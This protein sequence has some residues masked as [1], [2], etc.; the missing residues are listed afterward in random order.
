VRSTDD[1]AAYQSTLKYY[2]YYSS[3]NNISTLADC[4]AN[5]TLLNTTG[6]C[7]SNED[8]T[9]KYYTATGL[10]VG[11][12]CYFNVVVVNDA[13]QQT[14]YN[15]ESATISSSDLNRQVT[16]NAN[17]GAGSLRNAILRVLDG[18]TID[19]SPIAGQTVA[20]ASKLT[21]NKSVTIKGCGIK[22]DGSGISSDRIMAFSGADANSS[23]DIDRIHFANATGARSI[24]CSQRKP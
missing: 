1:I 12:T 15:G 17:D 19:C 13:N 7:E 8:G 21:V 5:G 23:L 9:R 20:L 6:A 3:S 11:V 16:T 4:L 2:F 18:G 24:Q 10:T 22:L 14:A